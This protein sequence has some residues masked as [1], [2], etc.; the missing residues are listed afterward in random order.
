M[1]FFIIMGLTAIFAIAAA[2]WAVRS[3]KKDAEKA[4]QSH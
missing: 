3:D 4:A 2:F 1:D